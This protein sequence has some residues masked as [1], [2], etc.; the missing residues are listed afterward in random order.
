[1][2][3]FHDKK[4]GRRVDESDAENVQIIH[5]CSGYLGYY[6]PAGTSDFYANDGRHQPGCGI[7]LSGTEHTTEYSIIDILQ[8][9]KY[10]FYA[11]VCVCL[12]VRC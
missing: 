8:L 4:P 1:M 10:Y 5:T 11:S 2:P 12:F 6:L 9:K 7:D 3:R